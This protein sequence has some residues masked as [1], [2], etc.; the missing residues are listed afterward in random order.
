M[1]DQHDLTLILKSRFPLVIIEIPEEPRVL[2]LIER[3]ANLEEMP[4]FKWSVSDG[5]KRHNKTEPSRLRFTKLMRSK[6]H[7]RHST[8]ARNSNAPNRFPLFAPKKC[9]RCANGRRI[10]R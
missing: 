1:N 9:K 2:A 8:L 3:I 5:I 6:R 4:L 7:S 10:V